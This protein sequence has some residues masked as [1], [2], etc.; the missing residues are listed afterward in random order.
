M[1]TLLCSLCGSEIEGWLVGFPVEE[2]NT[3]KLSGGRYVCPLLVCEKCEVLIEIYGL[4]GLGRTKLPY[5]SQTVLPIATGDPM[6]CKPGCYSWPCEH[7]GT[8]RYK[9]LTVYGYG[10][11]RQF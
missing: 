1:T 8:L 10:E 5:A 3:R 4:G 2:T 7:E 6:P 11:G 9:P